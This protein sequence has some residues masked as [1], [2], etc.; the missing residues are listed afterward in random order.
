[1]LINVAK[2]VDNMFSYV[3]F[4][5]ENLIGSVLRYLKFSISSNN[6][7]FYLFKPLIF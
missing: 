7:Y 2:I 3:N 6:S 5:E 1:M 4:S